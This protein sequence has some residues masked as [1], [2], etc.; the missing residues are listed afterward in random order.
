MN[1]IAYILV[2]VGFVLAG[3]SSILKRRVEHRLNGKVTAYYL[4]MVGAGLVWIVYAV[5]FPEHI[6]VTEG[7]AVAFIAGGG[8]LTLLALF[9]LFR[10]IRRGTGGRA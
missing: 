3:I 7:G 8:A 1:E 9:S 6:Q 10:V 2:G 5:A 4:F